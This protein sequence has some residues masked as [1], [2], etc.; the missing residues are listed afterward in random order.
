MKNDSRKNFFKLVRYLCLATA[1]IFG[2]IVIVATGG[3]SGG[4]GNDSGSSNLSYTGVETEAEINEDN[5]ET[6]ATGAYTGGVVGLGST[7]VGGVQTEEG[8]SDGSLRLYQISK[9]LEDSLRQVNQ[10]SRDYES[11]Q[12]ATV[13]ESGSF[14]GDCGG[15]ASYNINVD[16]QTG[17]FDG[18]IEFSSYCDLDVTL[19]G[20][21]SFSGQ[22]DLQTE[23]LLTFNLSF[24]NLNGNL[25]GDSITMSGDIS[26]GATV[27]PV[28]VSMDMLIK[29]NSSGD[30]Y[31]AHNYEMTISEGYDYIEIGVSGRFYDPNHGYVE[32]STPTLFRVYDYENNPERGVLVVTGKDNT[33]AR[34]TV[35]SNTSYHIE[36]D[37][38]GDDT[39]DYDGGT[40]NWEN[41]G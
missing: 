3:G 6:M 8:S 9:V 16:E 5:A 39:Y 33:K 11:V 32:I 41:I 26:V 22:L 19:N 7:S 40:A 2:L 4:D 37:T 35:I 29:D 27:S 20:S 10:D 24:N 38:D 34:L 15:G 28:T 17:E 30:V 31:Y 23:E 1:I 25:E 21:A 13:T 36:A 18:S 14:S 12:G